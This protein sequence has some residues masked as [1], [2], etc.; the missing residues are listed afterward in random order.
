MHNPNI[1]I[2]IISK[3][4][5]SCFV[6]MVNMAHLH[7]PD[8]FVA[9]IGSG[10][11]G[12][13]AGLALT[14]SARNVKPTVFERHTSLASAGGV[15]LLPPN[16]TRVFGSLGLLGSLRSIAED[17]AT[18]LLRDGDD[19]RIIQH[20]FVDSGG[21]APYLLVLRSEFLKWLLDRLRDR[22]ADVQ[23]G[24][25]VVKINEVQGAV[26]L[27]MADGEV[28]TVDLLIAADGNPGVPYCKVIY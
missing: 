5:P 1:L 9:I 24:K 20:R 28:S 23:F 6:R 19:G 27:E 22:G 21:E 18:H 25:H 4:R 15:I 7:N 3:R 10:I 2:A 16:A 12:L 26:E 11:A 14:Y 17:C 13:T 8:I